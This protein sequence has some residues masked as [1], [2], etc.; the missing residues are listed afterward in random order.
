VILYQETYRTTQRNTKVTDRSCKNTKTKST[1]KTHCGALPPLLHCSAGTEGD[2]W[3]MG[4]RQNSAQR[5]LHLVSPSSS[6]T[7]YTT[8]FTFTNSGQIHRPAASGGGEIEASS[9]VDLQTQQRR[10]IDARTPERAAIEGKSHHLQ[11]QSG[12]AASTPTP[13]AGHHTHPYYIYTERNEAPP[14]PPPAVRAAGGGRGT[15][16]I[17]A[18]EVVCLRDLTN[19]LSLLWTVDGERSS[20]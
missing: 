20:I 8:T 6:S 3:R 16:R 2:P 19:H 1:T 10:W 13:P 12:C 14:T 18:G 15:R 9:S 11:N 7:R 17:S 5:N 4:S